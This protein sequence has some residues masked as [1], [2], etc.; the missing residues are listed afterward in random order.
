MKPISTQ[1]Q[2]LARG[3][4]LYLRCI[5]EYVY[6][7]GVALFELIVRGGVAAHFD[8]VAGMVIVQILDGVRAGV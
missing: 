6:L 3:L 5:M 2:P 1:G 7:M 8:G 4:V